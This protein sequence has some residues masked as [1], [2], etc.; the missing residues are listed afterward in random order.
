MTVTAQP[1]RIPMTRDE[2]RRLPEGP[3]FY[4]YLDGEAVEVNRPT[5]RHQDILVCLAFALRRHVLQTDSGMV[6]A[7]A[8]VEL[9]SGDVVGPD[10]AFLSRSHLD[11][12]DEAKGDLHGAPDLAVETLSPSTAA[13]DRTEK[14]TRYHKAGVPWVWLVDQDSLAIEEHRWTPD[15]Y[16]WTG[17]TPGGQVFRPGLFPHLEIDLSS[18]LK[19]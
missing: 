9:P 1:R 12:C 18:L 8:D 11:L 19:G 17:A 13:Y 10:I 6:A 2:S 3:P 16:F 4:D 7:D 15:G 5:A 14:R